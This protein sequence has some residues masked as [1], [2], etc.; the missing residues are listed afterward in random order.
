MQVDD[1]HV[2]DGFMSIHMSAIETN[3]QYMKI[4]SYNGYLLSSSE[5]KA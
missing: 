1:K 4:R 2:D 3:F 5:R